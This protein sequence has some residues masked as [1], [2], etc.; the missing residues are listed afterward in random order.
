MSEAIVKS[1]CDN[2]KEAIHTHL[3]MLDEVIA[4]SKLIL[5]YSS[6]GDYDRMDAESTNRQRVIHIVEYIQG[7]IEGSI[8]VIPPSVFDQEISNTLNL[9][10]KSLANKIQEIAEI[11]NQLI[12]SIE[13]AKAEIQEDI[14]SMQPGKN[15][16]KGYHAGSVKR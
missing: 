5:K 15:S 1:T 7:R 3:K 16:L 6:N 2:L 12:K 13:K 10:Q 11:D 9:W 8:K 14:S 4:S